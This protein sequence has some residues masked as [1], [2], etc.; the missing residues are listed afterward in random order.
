MILTFIGI[1]IKLYHCVN[2][3]DTVRTES[4]IGLKVAAVSK[5][6]SMNAKSSHSA[7]LAGFTVKI[8]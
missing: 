1:I 7:D 4:C 2:V 3:S 5:E 8:L 6:M